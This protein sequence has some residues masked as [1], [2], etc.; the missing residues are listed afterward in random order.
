METASL[1]CVR[2]QETNSIILLSELNELSVVITVYLMCENYQKL[3]NFIIYIYIY[4][5]IYIRD[6]M[7]V[8]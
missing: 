8:E 1:I 5:Y 3:L 2:Y 6:D 4:I 7:K